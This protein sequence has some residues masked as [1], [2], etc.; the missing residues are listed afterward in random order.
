MDIHPDL[1]NPIVPSKPTRLKR[2]S[3]LLKHNVKNFRPSG[4]NHLDLA[5]TANQIQYYARNEVFIPYLHLAPPRYIDDIPMPS[6]PLKGRIAEPYSNNLSC[7]E[8]KDAIEQCFVLMALG[9]AEYNSLGA[10]CDFIN[11]AKSHPELTP[12][13]AFRSFEPD[14]SQELEKLRGTTCSGLTRAFLRS[15]EIDPFLKDLH[16]KGYAV[17]E[18]KPPFVE[19]HTA[20]MIPCNNGILFVELLPPP[21][22]EILR[23][24]QITSFEVNLP[25][26]LD[27]D[28]IANEIKIKTNLK[29][30]NIEGDYKVNNLVMI[31]SEL[32]SDAGE[33]MTMQTQYLLRGVVNPDAPVMTRY[34]LAMRVYPVIAKDRDGNEIMIKVNFDDKVVNFE[35][36]GQPYC[37]VKVPF[38][39]FDFETKEIDLSKEKD[40][41]K[42]A[43]MEKAI[44]QLVGSSSTLEDFWYE[45][46][47][48]QE[49]KEQ[50]FVLTREDNARIM[51]ELYTQ[52]K[53]D[54]MQLEPLPP[55]SETPNDSLSIQALDL[56]M[57][58]SRIY[59]R[60]KSNGDKIGIR[61]NVDEGTVTFERN[62]KRPVTLPFV[63]F[64]PQN[65]TIDF[66]R[67]EDESIRKD[68]EHEL[69]QFLG[70]GKTIED[71]WNEFEDPQKTRKQV[72]NL[73]LERL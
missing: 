2:S 59:D 73:T 24:D 26:E 44:E 53:R 14:S 10:V 61:V 58:A 47:A 52:V 29:V 35:R 67:E 65:Q 51:Q 56:D 3:P 33:E 57:S 11:H 41:I 49:L 32:I 8:V 27:Q 64:D 13:A 39:C 63:V 68:L 62:R 7:E 37:K 15:L 46:Q 70:N 22:I 5:M 18:K 31:K 4:V 1:P 12:A 38:E 72:F 19:N 20:V 36:N 54:K 21:R 23:K 30:V 60:A 55:A 17:M 50:V 48:P 9:T 43:K 6:Q 25:G 45:F 40:E 28:G 42:R 34:L 71:F 16:L 69:N 66:S